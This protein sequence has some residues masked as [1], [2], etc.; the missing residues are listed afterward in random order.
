METIYWYVVATIVALLPI[1]LIKQYTV[2]KNINYL[3]LT[4][5]LYLVL[6]IAYIQIFQQHQVSSSYTVL[7]IAQILIVCLMGLLIYGEPITWSVVVG[8]ISG[9]VSIYLLTG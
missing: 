4:M 8:L 1:Y 2:N 5:V 9:I 3:L 7:Q 6:M